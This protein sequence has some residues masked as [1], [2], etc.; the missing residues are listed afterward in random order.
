LESAR[1]EGIPVAL[2]VPRSMEGVLGGIALTY[3]AHSDPSSTRI[4]DHEALQPKLL[5]RVL[6]VTEE[7]EG[8]LVPLARRVWQSLGQRC[9]SG[10]TNRILYA[11]ASDDPGM[12]QV[13][14]RYV[15][16]SFSLGTNVTS[17]L[18]HADV[19][20]VDALARQVSSECEKTRQFARFSHLPS[21]GWFCSLSP[22]ANTLPLC[23]Q[24]FSRR[25]RG[26][27]FCM[28]DP[29]HGIAVFHEEG[30]R[31]ARVARLDA[32]MARQAREAASDVDTEE[33]RFQEMWATFY[34]SME[35]PGRD[36]T[37]RGYDLR[38]RFMPKRLWDSLPEL[39]EAPSS[40]FA[41]W[42]SKP[43]GAVGQQRIGDS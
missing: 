3:L 28:L 23:A 7:S 22:K 37:D 20:A 14:N 8:D 31:S 25:M 32:G 24:H 38:A 34:R 6:L 30:D 39:A 33:R 2:G 15:R 27:R 4:C 13:V 35:L 42:A 12:P 29:I 19:L 16:L 11:C 26:D 21:G 1:E 41:G 43:Q 17:S 36:A 40:P 18:A 10:C 5:E 9:G